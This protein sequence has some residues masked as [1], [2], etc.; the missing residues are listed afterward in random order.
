MKYGA[1]DSVSR[2]GIVT[3]SAP[4]IVQTGR[5]LREAMWCDGDVRAPMSDAKFLSTEG[6][7]ARLHCSILYRLQS[8]ESVSRCI[9]EGEGVEWCL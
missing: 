9:E 8:L 4:N 6:K 2:T 5:V 1:F 3:L 7:D